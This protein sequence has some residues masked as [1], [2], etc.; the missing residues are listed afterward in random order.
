MTK[1][2]TTTLIFESYN[3]G[4][5]TLL[6]NIIIYDKQTVG[7]EKEQLKYGMSVQYLNDHKVI[8]EYR[9]N[10]AE[11][12]EFYLFDTNGKLV[13]K[14]LVKNTYCE[15]DM[16]DFPVGIFLASVIQ[17]DQKYNS[18]IINLKS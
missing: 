17:K 14:Q 4:S 2:G 12:W 11:P 10:D 13:L 6:D 5:S 7:T 1:N 3:Y 8:V 16:K 15:I 18:K 9:S